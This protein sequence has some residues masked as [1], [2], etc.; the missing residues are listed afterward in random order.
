M[1][2]ARCPICCGKGIVRKDFYEISGQSTTDGWQPVACKACNGRGIIMCDDG[3][4]NIFKYTY[5]PVSTWPYNHVP[6]WDLIEPP[7]IYCTSSNTI[8]SAPVTLT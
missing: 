6:Y 3:M 1:S 4:L 7:Y 5:T 8:A 2:P